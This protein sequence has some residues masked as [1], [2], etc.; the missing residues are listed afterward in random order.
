MTRCPYLPDLAPNVYFLFPFIKNKIRGQRFNSSEE[1][2]ETYMCH[3][4]AMSLSEWY[5][6]FENWFTQVQKCISALVYFG[7]QQNVHSW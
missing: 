3:A 7:K 2:I 4:A 1:V 5:N 6:C